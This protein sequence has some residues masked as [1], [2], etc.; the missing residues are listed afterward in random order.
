M[1]GP[2]R[3]LDRRGFETGP[4]GVV[5]P[6]DLLDPSCELAARR[7]HD[8]VTASSAAVLHAGADGRAAVAGANGAA[9]DLDES[10]SGQQAD[11]LAVQVELVPEILYSPPCPI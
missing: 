10:L 4:G 9:N 11:G 1:R 5:R 8:R 7:S 6:A 3:A 2:E